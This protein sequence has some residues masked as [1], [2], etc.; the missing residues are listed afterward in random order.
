[1]ADFFWVGGTGNWNDY[2][3]HWATSSG[4][5]TMHGNAPT[6]SDDVYFDANSASGGFTVTVN[7][8]ANMNIFDCSGLNDEMQLVNAA[9]AFNVYRHFRLS[10]SSFSASFSSTGYLYFKAGGAAEI[11]SNGCTSSWNRIYFDGSGGEWTNQDAWNIGAT[12]IY[13]KNGT[14]NINNKVISAVGGSFYTDTGTKTLTFGSGTITVAGWQIT[15]TGLT[16]NYDTGTINCY[17]NFYGGGATYYSVNHYTNGN[18]THDGANTYTNLSFLVESANI[19][20]GF[21]IQSNIIISGTLTITGNNAGKYRMLIASNTIGTARTITCNTT[22][23]ASNVDFRDITGAGTASWD[24]S[25]ITGLSGDCGGNSGITFTTGVPQYWHVGTGSWSDASKWFT[26]TNGGGSAGRVPLPQDDVYFDADSFDSSGVI[27]VNCP[28]IGKSLDMSAVN[29]AVTFTMNNDTIT[30]G[31]YV[32]GN[33]ITR[34]GNYI[35]YLNGRGS[36]NLNTY[37]KSIYRLI[38]NSGTYLNLSDLTL[39]TTSYNNAINMNGNSILVP[40]LDFNDYNVTAARITLT[41]N[42]NVLYLG[43]GTIS[44]YINDGSWIFEAYSANT[45]NCEQSTIKLI[46]ASGSSNIIFTGGG[47]TFYNVW[48]SGSHTG[49]F[50][51]AGSNTYNEIKID[52]GRKVRVTAGTTQTFNKLTAVGTALTG[53]ITITSVTNASHILSLASGQPDVEC[54]YL[55]LSYSQAT[56]SKFYAGSNSTDGGNNTGWMFTDP[57]KGNFMLFF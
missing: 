4:G 38:I 1:M 48:F 41:I 2:G 8:T 43:N 9:Y 34:S 50:D 20:N 16:F 24:L 46:P 52:P 56:A 7:A 42:S 53:M 11:T 12:S 27:T 32:L 6:S 10:G 31:S 3:S 13:L 17:N 49:N 39:P 45:I 37:V 30:H 55:S 36:H 28:R 14:W 51:I 57:P 44:L 35:T 21:S 54:D 15:T 26:A 29:Q 18:R 19:V 5:E 25:A 22:V 23:T 33:N 47:K 40:T